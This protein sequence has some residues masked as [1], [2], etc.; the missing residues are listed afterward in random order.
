MRGALIRNSTKM[1][2]K[3]A[4]RG[5][6]EPSPARAVQG[7]KRS[8]STKQLQTV[9]AVFPDNKNGNRAYAALEAAAGQLLQTRLERVDFEKLD[10]GETASLDRFYA[11]NVAVVD[12][13]E[14]NMQ[15]AL[16]Y[17]LGLRENFD[18]KN[19]VVTVLESQ[20][21]F[22]EPSLGRI[23]GPAAMVRFYFISG[24][25][26]K[27]NT[28]HCTAY[29]HFLLLIYTYICTY[30]HTHLRRELPVPRT[31]HTR[32]TRK[33]TPSLERRGLH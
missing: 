23:D 22:G 25:C 14:R 19:N 30:T 10:Y 32:W 33:A 8:S 17:Q 28:I 13:T 15:A 24:A 29:S 7:Q 31:S 27:Y 9:V 11:A 20:S 5:S 1:A 3:E 4:K 26:H 18:M 12:V 16:F 21:E 2:S 6:K